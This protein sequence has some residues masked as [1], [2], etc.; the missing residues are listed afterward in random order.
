VLKLLLMS[1]LLAT[2]LLPAVAASG[3]KPFRALRI[4]L[5]SMLVA[6]LAYAFFLRFIFG[7]ML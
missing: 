5:V 3:R 4:T 7:H 6:E 1:V 2:F